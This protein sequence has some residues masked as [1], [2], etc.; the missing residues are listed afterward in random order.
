M[1]LRSFKQLWGCCSVVIRM[2]RVLEK[3]RWTM[4]PKQRSKVHVDSDVM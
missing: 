4:R 2:V 1:P 3:S